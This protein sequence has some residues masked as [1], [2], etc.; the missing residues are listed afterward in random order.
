MIKKEQGKMK[1]LADLQDAIRRLDNR[2]AVMVGRDA[3][4]SS[5]D[6]RKSP[7]NV[8]DKEVLLRQEEM[9][10]DL[11]KRIKASPSRAPPLE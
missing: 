9:A 5:R 8:T 10:G 11:Y 7:E 3:G 2:V 6:T 4:R 1:A